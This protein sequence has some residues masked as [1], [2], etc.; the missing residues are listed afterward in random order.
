MNAEPRSTSVFMNGGNQCV[1]IPKD[2]WFAEDVKRV[3]IVRLGADV[4][5]R[6][7]KTRR[8]WVSFVGEPTCPDD[9]EPAKWDFG[10][11]AQP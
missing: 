10:D 5:L 2:L 7:L 3:E 4:I 9:F 6:P 8:P 11:E 1:R